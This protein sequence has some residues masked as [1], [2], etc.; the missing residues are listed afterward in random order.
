M[1]HRSKVSG[2]NFREIFCCFDLTRG[3]DVIKYS[4][5]FILVILFCGI[6]GRYFNPFWKVKSERKIMVFWGFSFLNKIGQ[7]VWIGWKPCN[8]LL[9]NTCQKW[10]KIH[11]FLDF[12]NYDNCKLFERNFE[13]SKNIIFKNSKIQTVK[14]GFISRQFR[15]YFQEI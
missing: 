5:A 9:R 11:S 4:T 15:I 13:F 8:S 10:S 7:K 1:N 2:E 3:C 12:H 14:S 6:L